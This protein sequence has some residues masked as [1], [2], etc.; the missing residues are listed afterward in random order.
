MRSASYD[1]QWK[2]N[3][4]HGW[5]VYTVKEVTPFSIQR[6]EG[7]WFEDARTGKGITTG[8]DGHMEMSVYENGIRV[9]EGVRLMNESMLLP[10]DNEQRGPWRLQDAGYD[11]EIEEIEV[12]E[13]AAIAKR[14]GLELPR[15]PN[16]GT[17]PASLASHSSAKSG[18][19]RASNTRRP[20]GK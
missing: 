10:Y 13:A 5:G 8:A 17:A 12:E 3:K 7:E 9:G 14:I 16:F 11:R 18:A 20:P 19:S 2:D 1:G 4:R 15:D 6:Y